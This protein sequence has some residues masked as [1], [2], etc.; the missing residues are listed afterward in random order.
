M[1]EN[2]TTV[3]SRV[4]YGIGRQMGDQLASNPVDG[5][6]ID[7][8]LAGLAD[9][10]NGAASAV[11]PADLQSAFEQMQKRMQAQQAEKA[12]V[13]AADGEAYLAENAKRDGV[14][15]TTSGLQFEVLVEGS[16]PKP[17]ASSTVKTH[18]HGTLID[19]T[20]FDSSVERGQPAE[21]PVNGVISGWTEALQ[22]MNTG[23]KWRLHVPYQLA[24]GERGAGGA[25]GPYATLVFEVELLD[26]VA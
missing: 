10:L 5:L 4:S 3:E 17:T 16:G 13:M 18:Y 1:S 19:G 7:A 14:Q 22:M 25:I 15:V 11:A 26:I 24:Y 21:F 6:S 23:S 2:Y 20:V 9:S 8:V 12:K